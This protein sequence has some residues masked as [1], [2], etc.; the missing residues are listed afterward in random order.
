VYE[1]DAPR[2]PVKDARPGAE[3]PDT[4]MDVFAPV[5]TGYPRGK[6]LGHA[7]R[8]AVRTRGR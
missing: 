3:H 1:L 2:V 8:R 7:P 6:K 4:Y 5:N